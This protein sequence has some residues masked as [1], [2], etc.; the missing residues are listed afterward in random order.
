LYF[1]IRL[2]DCPSFLRIARQ[3]TDEFLPVEDK[4]NTGRSPGSVLML[5]YCDFR[6]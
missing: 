2:D 5:S 6:V 4:S 3:L 1:V